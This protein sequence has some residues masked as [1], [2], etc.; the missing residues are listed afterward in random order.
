MESHTKEQFERELHTLYETLRS[1]GISPLLVNPVGLNDG[2]FSLQLLLSGVS[3]SLLSAHD[4]NELIAKAHAALESSSAADGSP[5][6]RTEP[7]TLPP[8]VAR[9]ILPAF[10][11]DLEDDTE[12]SLALKTNG[13][14]VMGRRAFSTPPS[15]PTLPPPPH[16][17]P[18]PP[19]P[20][21]PP[22]P[23]PP[24]PHPTPPRQVLRSLASGVPDCIYLANAGLYLGHR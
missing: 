11:K 20:H 17:H 15:P 9:R 4:K 5:P 8:A 2:T 24:S 22:S 12:A 16:P 23:P 18:H 10:L 1:R 19:P 13:E 14:K 6:P 7:L 21:P 3:E